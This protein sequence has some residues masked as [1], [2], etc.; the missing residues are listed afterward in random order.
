MYFSYARHNIADISCISEDAFCCFSC[1]GKLTSCIAEGP[2]V[3]KDEV[4]LQIWKTVAY[5][6]VIR[7][8]I[9]IYS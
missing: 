2:Q 4:S 6:S 5:S 9:Q 1:H 3:L 8:T 7:L